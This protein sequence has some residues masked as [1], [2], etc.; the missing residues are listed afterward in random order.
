MS[1]KV[2]GL[3]ALLWYYATLLTTPGRTVTDLRL[4]IRVTKILAGQTCLF[5]C[6]YNLYKLTRFY[7]TVIRMSLLVPVLNKVLVIKIDVY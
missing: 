4:S 3:A 1:I 2:I 6:F 5:A 7:L